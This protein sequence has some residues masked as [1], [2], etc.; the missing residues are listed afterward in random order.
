MNY[1]TPA[2]TPR[3]KLAFLL[4]EIMND[5]AP[6][7]WTR[8]RGYAACLLAS[9]KLREILREEDRKKRADRKADPRR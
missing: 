2:D 4:S 1:E 6:L 5:S 3:D 7:G 8:Y 9:D